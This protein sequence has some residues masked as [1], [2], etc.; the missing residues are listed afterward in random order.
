M[1]TKILKLPEV[2]KRTGL[3][4]STIYAE[5]GKGI[6]PKQI[7][8]SERSSG[9]LESEIDDWIQQRVELSRGGE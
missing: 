2:I 5:I 7:K 3:S 9:W 1:M 8:L 6:F 4:K